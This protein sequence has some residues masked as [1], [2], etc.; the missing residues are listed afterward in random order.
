MFM[1]E[2]YV[3]ETE[4]AQFGES[5]VFEAFTDDI[6][7]L[8]RDLQREYGRCAS[9][10]YRDTTNGTERIGWVFE[11]VQRYERS[12]ETNKRAVWVT[13]YDSMPVTVAPTAHVLA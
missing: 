2:T 6:G 13:L 8:F 5:D 12:E 10:I 9:S 7:K 11:S 3:N 1:Q 4:N